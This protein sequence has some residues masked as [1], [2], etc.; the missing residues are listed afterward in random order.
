MLTTNDEY[1]IDG[2]TH[3]ASR[4]LSPDSLDEIP[5]E[6]VP[7]VLM[8]LAAAQARLAGRLLA[9]VDAPVATNGKLLK[10]AAASERMGC[11]VDWLYKHVADLPFVVRVGRSLRFSES[12]IEKWIRARSGR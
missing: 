5:I 4:F 7:A 12:G 10:V 11:S 3:A 9:A 1:K 8:Q 2:R 6:R